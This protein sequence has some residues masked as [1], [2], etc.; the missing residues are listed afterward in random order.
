MS[1]DLEA[2]KKLYVGAARPNCHTLM[3]SLGTP[4]NDPTAYMPAATPLLHSVRQ[5]F[6][7]AGV[8]FWPVPL[9]FNFGRFKTLATVTLK[10]TEISGIPELVTGD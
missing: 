9:V 2:E 4:G 5:G 6:E 1:S 3:L 8:C 10:T 7:N